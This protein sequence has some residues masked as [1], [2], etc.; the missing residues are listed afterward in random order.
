GYTGEVVKVNPESV[1]AILNAGYIPVIAPGGYRTSDENDDRVRLLN[2][3]GDD[4]ASEIAMSLEAE[5]LIFLTDVPGVQNGEGQ[6]L[7]RL[8]PVEARALIESGVISGGMIPK[9]E[10]CLRALSSVSSTQI[11]DG[12]SPGALLAALERNDC[13]TIIE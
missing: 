11:I 5:R 8:S 10:G 9:V 3:N 4:S 7:S 13:G 12:Q 2:I 6:L 1:I